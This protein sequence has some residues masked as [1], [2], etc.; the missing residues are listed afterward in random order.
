MI[1]RPRR[2]V[3]AMPGSNARALEKGKT[4]AADV[5]MFELED[6]VAEA[7]KE[8]AREQV[9]AAVKGGG[10]G[11]REIIVR[12]N[13][14]DSPWYA[15]DMAAVAAAGPDAIVVP[16]AN[17]RD[18]ILRAARD[19]KAA[20]APAHTTLWAMIETPRA[21]FDIEKIA[22]AA[23]EAPLS[24]MMLGPNDIAK[25]TRARLTPGRPALVSWLSSAVLAARLHNVD[26]IDGIYNDFNDLE[27]LRREAEQGRDLGMD[28]KML[29]HPGQIA[30]VNEVFAPS[31]AEIAFAR[32]IVEL[33]DAPENAAIGV[34]QIDGRMVE[35][36]HLDGARRALAL[37]GASS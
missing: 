12:V 19:M 22:S 5:L 24:A 35:R 18:D 30:T 8:M 29:I 11:S 16:K 10:Y 37:A 36:L 1:S 33:F 32:K 34:A 6:G 25:S 20:G 21:L 13:V 3:L 28:G 2:S 7:A 14:L 31:P 27:G 4:L 17:S 9:V 23:P 15:A 26:I